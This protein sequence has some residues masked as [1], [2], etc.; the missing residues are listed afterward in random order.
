MPELQPFQ[1]IALSGGSVLDLGSP[2]VIPPLT[3]TGSFVVSGLQVDPLPSGIRHVAKY[4]GQRNVPAD[5]VRQRRYTYELMRRMGTPVI[6][7]KMFTDRDVR[8]KLAKPSP[9]FHSVY[10]QVRNEDRISHGTGFVSVEEAEHEYIDTSGKIFYSASN[11]GSEFAKAPKYRGF[12]PGYLTYII[13]PDV[14]EDFYKHTPE[15]VFVRIQQA[16]ALSPWWP[17]INDNDLIIH[18]TL[19][20]RGDVV[21]TQDRYQAK[22]VDPVSIRGLDRRGRREYTGDIGNR[23]VINQQFEMALMPENNVVYKVEIDR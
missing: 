21:E 10:K 23:Y 20:E 1:P 7:K 15:G 11:P 22:M 17:D 4:V 14:A 2:S 16:R 19:N 6:I 18:V 5:I 9:N 3:G 13:E 12:G 8:Y